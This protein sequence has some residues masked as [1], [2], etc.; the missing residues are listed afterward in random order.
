MKRKL[1]VKNLL[2]FIGIILIIIGIVLVIVLKPKNKKQN[3]KEKAKSVE[4]KEEVP[5]EKVDIIDINSKTRPFAVAINNTPVAVKVQTGLNKAYMVYE[6][7]TEG[8]TSRLLAFYKDTDD[9]TIGTI[10][11]ARHNFIDFALESDAIFV[12]YGYSHYAE[13]ELKSGKIDYINGM[14]HS[15]PFWRDNPE[16]LASEHTAYTSINNIKDFAYD[17]KH[18]KKESDDAKNTVLLN[19]NVADVDLSNMENVMDANEVK[20]PYGSVTTVFKYNPDSKMYTRVVNGTTTKDHK[21]NEEFTTKNII[22]ERITYNQ[23][24][25]GYYWNL[26]T[27]GNGDGY[28]ITNGKAVPIKWSK[29]S[30]EA[31]TKYTYEDGKEIEVS[32]GRTYIEVQVTNQRTTIN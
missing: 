11:S 29:S 9:F 3:N 17:T 18:Y 5:K 12:A 28:Y 10:R 22:V 6:I 16:G 19:Y 23:A 15:K 25:D 2:I 24:S 8:S 32:D 1:N 7:P 14:I 13:D 30:R 27:T 20:V 26:H 4:K 21:T 31:K